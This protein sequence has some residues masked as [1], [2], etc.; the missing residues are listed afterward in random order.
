M[1][2]NQCVQRTDW[3]TAFLKVCADSAVVIGGVCIKLNNL[4]RSQKGI[5]CGVVFRRILTVV[6]AVAQPK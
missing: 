2:G 1:S 5:Q 3:H 4:K 6:G